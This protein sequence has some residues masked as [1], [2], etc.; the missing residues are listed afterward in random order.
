MALRPPLYGYQILTRVFF[1]TGHHDHHHGYGH[2]HGKIFK[3]DAKSMIFLLFEAR[4]GKMYL[5]SFSY[6]QL[7]YNENHLYLVPFWTP[8]ALMCLV[9]GKSLGQYCKG[10]VYS[11]SNSIY[12]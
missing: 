12:H 10:S 11:S 2:K 5:I 9:K 6:Y 3:D 4:I 1:C 8:R 7:Y